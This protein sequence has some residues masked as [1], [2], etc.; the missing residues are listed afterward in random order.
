VKLHVTVTSLEPIPQLPDRKDN[1]FNNFVTV[2][3]SSDSLPAV[4][5]V[6]RSPRQVASLDVATRKKKIRLLEEMGADDSHKK[7]YVPDDK[8]PIRQY[9]R[10]KTY[11]PMVGGDWEVDS[12]EDS[13][14]DQW[15]DE[16][17]MS[18]R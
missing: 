3:L 17:T 15:L 12:D 11:Q 16:I 2:G 18:V 5:F 6:K 7:S 8:V 14:T 13:T 10:S 1:I 9:F 4:P